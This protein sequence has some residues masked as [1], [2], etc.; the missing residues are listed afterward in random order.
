[1]LLDCL[2]KTDHEEASPTLCYLSEDPGESIS[3]TGPISTRTQNAQSFE[4]TGVDF[5]G[6]LYMRGRDE[7]KVYVY[8]FTCAVSRAVHLEI[9]TN[10]SVETFL[11]AFR[12]FSSRKSLPKILISDNALTYMAAAEELLTTI[13]VE[14]KAM[15]ND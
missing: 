13:I 1:M 2:C 4:F 12:R 5:T 10:L 7:N 14:V 3:N 6:A 8:L 11:L 9:V 15:L